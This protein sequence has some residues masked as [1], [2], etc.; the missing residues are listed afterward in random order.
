MTPPP[1]QNFKTVGL[2]VFFLICCSTISF[3]L[4]VGLRLT[5]GY[6]TISPS[7]ESPFDISTLPLKHEYLINSSLV[8]S[9]THLYGTCLSET[10]I[11]K[12]FD[13]GIKLYSSKLQ[14]IGCDTTCWK[15]REKTSRRQTRMRQGSDPNN[16]MTLSSIQNLN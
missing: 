7:R 14:T 9:F 5:L 6:L 12:T 15:I 16:R 11:K 2:W 10:S 3:I 1:T 13:I 4:N 8:P